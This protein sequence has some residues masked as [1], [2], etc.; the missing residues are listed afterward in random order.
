VKQPQPD[1]GRYPSVR[2]AGFE[3]EVSPCTVRTLPSDQK[4][5]RR[6]QRF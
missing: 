6:Y 2:S 4:L 5:Q 1:V 3:Q